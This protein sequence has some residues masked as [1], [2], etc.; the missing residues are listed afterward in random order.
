MTNSTAPANSRDELL[1][2]L[3]RVDVEV[4]GRLVEQQQIGLATSALASSVRRRQPPDS[5]LDRPVRRQSQPRDH[6]LDLLLEAPALFAVEVDG[7]CPSAARDLGLADGAATPRA[8]RSRRVAGPRTSCS[9]RAT[10][11]PGLAPD[12]PG[13]ERDFAGDGLQQARLAAAVAA[14]E[15]DPLAR[16][17]P[18]VGVL[19]ERQVPE[20]QT[21]PC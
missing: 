12:R 18:Q 1:D 7:Q 14:D 5:S 17:D 3:D 10:R 13:V 21:C 11:R 8:A 15:R 9:S 4:V 2:P 16:L 6:Q 19:E 20:G